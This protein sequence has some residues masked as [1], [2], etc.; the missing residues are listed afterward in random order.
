MPN[1]IPDGS[2]SE[3]AQKGPTV[4]WFRDMELSDVGGIKEKAGL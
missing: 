4:D 3:H 2:C 1:H